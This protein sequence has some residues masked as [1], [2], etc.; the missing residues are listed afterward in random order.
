M[1]APIIAL[2]ALFAALTTVQPAAATTGGIC[3]QVIR[4]ASWDVLN[5]RA[6]RSASSRIVGEIPPR[7]HGIIA[8]TGSCLPRN[9]PQG[10]R[11]CRI[12]YHDSD[13]SVSGYVKRRFLRRGE[14][15]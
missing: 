1:K 15:P 14:C 5:I 2:L 10:S 8:L 3:Y 6:R 11:W 9:A 13:Y 7:R 4:V 12:T